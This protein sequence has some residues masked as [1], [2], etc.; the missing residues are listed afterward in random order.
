MA[1]LSDL[2]LSKLF[3]VTTLQWLLLMPAVTLAQGLCPRV[4]SSPL[5]TSFADLGIFFLVGF[6]ILAVPLFLEVAPEISAGR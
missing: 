2:M 3:W 1:D 5:I 6:V 4:S